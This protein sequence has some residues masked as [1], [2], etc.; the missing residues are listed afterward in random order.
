MR[1][2]KAHISDAYSI[3]SLLKKYTTEGELL[4]RP[5]ADIFA[6]IRDFYIL[7]DKKH[8]AGII[9]LH[10]YWEDLGEI[11]SFIIEKKYRGLGFGGKLLANAVKEAEAIGIKKV[12]ALTKIPEFFSKQGF[13]RISRTKLPHKV[14][15]DCFNCPKYPKYCDEIALIYRIKQAKG[16]VIKAV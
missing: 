9:A 11:R 12:F 6:Q 4:V 3:Q 5:M 7:E 2:R 8:M 15:K 16:R 1:I 14:W 10:V 13:K